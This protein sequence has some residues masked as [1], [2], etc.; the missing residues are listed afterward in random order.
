MI[1]AVIE[2]TNTTNRARLVAT[3]VTA[4]AAV[5]IQPSRR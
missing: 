5:T 2:P 3:I 4:F 1:A